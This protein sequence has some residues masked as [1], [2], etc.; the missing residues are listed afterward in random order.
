MLV[1]LDQENSPAGP[2]ALVEVPIAHP[3]IALISRKETG[4]TVLVFAPSG[5]SPSVHHT[6]KAI[7]LTYPE[8]RWAYTRSVEHS[9]PFLDLK[10]ANLL[11]IKR[12]YAQQHQKGSGVIKDRFPQRPS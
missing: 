4:K 3:E 1:E 7:E 10:T 2:I 6:E 11:Q 9:E 8:F 5:I 12:D